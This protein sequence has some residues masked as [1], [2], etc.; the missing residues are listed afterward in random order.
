MGYKKYLTA[1][2]A[3]KAQI[4]QTIKWR[5]DN[6][7]QYKNTLEKRR[8]TL[9]YKEK[10]KEVNKRYKENNREKINSCR[11]EYARKRKIEDNLF[12]FKENTKHNIRRSFSRGFK[13]F[14]K[15][16]HTEEILGCSLDF[17]KEYILSLCPEGITLKDF[18]KYGY[19]LDH[20]IPISSAETEEEVTKL[21][22]YT[23]FQPLWYIENI[24]K[25]NKI[26]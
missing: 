25:S 8:Q 18:G 7:E 26:Q 16:L 21:C 15:R 19:H 11:R 9:E 10:R 6:P 24:K 22:H 4:A 13:N 2:E 14:T 12:K 20:I 3:K 5:K 23:N 1:E 17:F